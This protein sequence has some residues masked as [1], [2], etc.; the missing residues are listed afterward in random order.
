MF[1]QTIGLCCQLERPGLEQSRAITLLV[2]NDGKNNP[3]PK[4]PHTQILCEAVSVL[5]WIE[6]HPVKSVGTELFS[7]C[8]KFPRATRASVL[9]RLLQ[10]EIHS[11]DL[12]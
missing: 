4:R 7:A 12:V 10:W 2:D 3:E 6:R 11:A 1:L 8:A 5:R 9:H